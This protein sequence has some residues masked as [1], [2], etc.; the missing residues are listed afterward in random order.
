[1][2]AEP[3]MPTSLAHRLSPMRG[4][5][6]HEEGRASTPLELLFDLTFVV[7]FGKA[8]EEMAHAIAADHLSVGLVGFGFAMFG[9]IWAWI[10]FSWFASAYDTDDWIYRV[11][12]MVQ[13]VG[14]VI[15]TLG[16]PRMFASLE[17]GDHLDNS[18]MVLGYVVMR[19]AM[20]A[21]WLRAARQCPGDMRACLTY[22]ATLVIAQVGWIYTAVADLPTG[23]FFLVAAPLI[24][25]ELAGPAIAETRMGGTPW[26][27][28]HIAERYGLLAIITLGEGVIGT[29]A[30]VGATSAGGWDSGAVY[31]AAAG[32]GLTFGMWWVYFVMPSGT[33]LHRH[34]E[35]SFIWGYG[36]MPLFAAIAAV[37]AGLHV[38]AYVVEHEHGAP[39][40]GFVHIG[41]LGAVVAVAVPVAVFVLLVYALYTYLVRRSDPL[42]LVL[43]VGTAVVI[44]LA[45]WLAARDVSMSVCLLVLMAA[46]LVSVVGYELL[47]HRHQ[48][49]ALAGDE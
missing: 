26:H 34:R 30:S 40:A 9:V 32:I 17:H 41:S 12:T 3:A 21:Q 24:L 25:V 29:V 20:L 35:R 48:A 11:T 19:V 37:G 44:A 16:L 13:M 1:M 14:V 5:D 43:L 36:H 8:G 15:L 7:A 23:V 47:G 49:E 39:E 6:P 28:H 33:V 38:A 45:I 18:V 27:A 4:R 10:N 31:V 42:H 46:P 2:S 22:A